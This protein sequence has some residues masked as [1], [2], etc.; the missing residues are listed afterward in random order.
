MRSTLLP[1]D[2]CTI[3]DNAW[4]Q[5]AGTTNSVIDCAGKV[6]VMVLVVLPAAG[7]VTVTFG[8]ATIVVKLALLYRN[9]SAVVAVV[10][11]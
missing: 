5:I 4:N 10:S 3:G 6:A 1:Q 7:G 2:D 11:G 9:D 8:W